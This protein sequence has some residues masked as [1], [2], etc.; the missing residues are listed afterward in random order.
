MAQQQHHHT[1]LAVIKLA[2]MSRMRLWHLLGFPPFG[3]SM[4]CETLNPCPQARCEG[5]GVASCNGY[6][7]CP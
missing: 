5:K 1:P 4:A 3:Q 7:M 6:L 2:V